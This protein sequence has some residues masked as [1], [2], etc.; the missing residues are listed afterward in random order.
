MTWRIELFGGPRLIAKSRESISHFPTQKAAALLAYLALTLPRSHSREVIAELF[1]P[2]RD[3]A[4]S[5]NNLAVT[6]SRLRALVGDALVSTRLQVGLNPEQVTTDVAEFEARLAAGDLEGA[7]RLARAEL[8][9]GLYDDWV[10]TERERL[11][12]RLEA[13][14]RHSTPRHTPPLFAPSTPLPSHNLPKP[15]TSFVGREREHSEVR[16]LLEKAR[17]VTLTG[18]GGSGKTR[19]SQEV[20]WDTLENFPEGV[21]LV[22]LAALTDPALLA[23][24]VAKVLGVAERPELPL[25]TGLTAFLR[26]KKALLLLD[27]CEHVLEASATLAQALLQG[28]PHLQILATSRE[29]LGVAGEHPYR[30]PSLALDDAIQL[31]VERAALHRPEL[32]HTPQSTSA[33]EA[34]CTRLDGIPLAIELAAARLRSLSIGELQERLAHSF[35]LLTGG[36]RTALPRHQT[37]RALIDWS[38]ALLNQSEKTLLCRLSVFAGGWSLRAAENVCS[39]EAIHPSEVLDVL[40]SLVDKSLVITTEHLGVTRYRL[41]ETVR[42]YAREHLQQSGEEPEVRTQHLRYFIA[43]TEEH[44][45]ELDNFRVALAWASEG[46]ERWESHLRL[47]EVLFPLWDRRNYFQEGRHWCQAALEKIPP[48]TKT[49]LVA[50]VLHA[51]GQLA[52]VQGDLEQARDYLTESLALFEALDD[53]AGMA[54]ALTGLANIAMR[55]GDLTAQHALHSRSLAL[56]REQ[57]DTRGIAQCLSN[58]GYAELLLNQLEQAKAYLDE[59]LTLARS[60][61]DLWLTAY[62]TG[63]LGVLAIKQG[64]SRAA[65]SAFRESLLIQRELLDRR[66]IVQ[67]LETLAILDAMEGQTERAVSLF[68]AACSL[69]QELGMSLEP[70]G[71]AQYDQ[72]REALRQAH[73]E[74]ALHAAQAKGKSLPLD[75]VISLALQET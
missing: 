39:G 25:L 61:G 59:S 30:T 48:G 37:L 73:G 62:T 1:W 70:V 9:P 16:A 12:A 67:L 24:T 14:Q 65:R 10:I 8:L 28:C 54:K 20:A 6:I 15:L 31:F 32:A 50:S 21:F 23:R 74:A 58:L 66:I 75:H 7:T 38:Y 26:E 52:W 22:E 46:T 47:C 51:T 53:R 5:R 40:T 71:K 57:E 36:S 2:D 68:A 34:I 29:A 27:N 55:K 42:Q 69:R 60:L 63:Y 33:L 49:S 35:A 41:L 43:L 45:A 3:P 11:V 64:D 72:A 19:L 17:L 56:C 13:C 44:E 18:S 4:L